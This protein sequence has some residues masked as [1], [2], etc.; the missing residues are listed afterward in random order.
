MGI[1]TQS[2]VAFICR[3]DESEWAAP[4]TAPPTPPAVQTILDVPGAG[5]WEHE[6]NMMVPIYNV[7]VR[8]NGRVIVLDTDYYGV[9]GPARMNLPVSLQAVVCQS[10]SCQGEE[11][12]PIYAVVANNIRAHDFSDLN[13]VLKPCWFGLEDERTKVQEAIDEASEEQEATYSSDDFYDS[14]ETLLTDKREKAFEDLINTVIQIKDLATPF[15]DTPALVEY[16]EY[17]KSIDSEDADPEDWMTDYG[18]TPMPPSRSDYSNT[19]VIDHNHIP[20]DL[21]EILTEE[22]VKAVNEQ[23]EAARKA[24]AEKDVFKPTVTGR[25]RLQIRE[26]FLAAAVGGAEDTTGIW[27]LIDSKAGTS[28]YPVPG[29]EMQRLVMYIASRLERPKSH[30]AGELETSTTGTH[31]YNLID[32]LVLNRKWENF[33]L[34]N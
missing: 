29:P 10:Y 11:Q 13:S 2:K 5:Y 19:D 8:N 30:I 14:I 12:D 3:D 1:S 32:Y 33:E 26:A 27:R 7:D 23:Y 17:L 9:I 28:A 31:I 15:V 18:G 24:E 25:S 16:L 34:P 22:Q 20:I 6:D 21:S 4:F